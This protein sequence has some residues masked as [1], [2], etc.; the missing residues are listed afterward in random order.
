MSTRRQN[1]STKGLAQD[2][3][4]YDAAVGTSGYNPMSVNGAW[5]RAIPSLQEKFLTDPSTGSSTNLSWSNTAPNFVEFDIKRRSHADYLSGPTW[6]SLRFN[7]TAASTAYGAEYYGVD[8]L[9]AMMIDKVEFIYNTRVL[10]R[11]YGW[12]LPEWYN[13]LPS[14]EATAARVGC[15]GGFSDDPETITARKQYLQQADNYLKIRLFTPWENY[16]QGIWVYALPTA[17]T[18]RVTFLPNSRFIAHTSTTAPTATYVDRMNLYTEGTHYLEAYRQGMYNSLYGAG[19]LSTKI[20]TTDV[21][22]PTALTSSTTTFSSTVAVPLRQLAN[23]CYL[24]RVNAYYLGFQTPQTNSSGANT[25]YEAAPSEYLP[26]ENIKLVD[27][28]L[29]ITD[30]YYYRPKGGLTAKCTQQEQLDWLIDPPRIFPESAVGRKQALI[31]FCHPVLCEA[32]NYDGA[33][34]TIVPRRYT[35][36]EIVIKLPDET[37]TGSARDT[38]VYRYPVGTGA[39]VNVQLRVQAFCHNFMTQKNGDI[40]TLFVQA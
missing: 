39:Q 34:G 11:V 40:K 4:F 37:A 29:Q 30:T 28:A 17:L 33:F 19:A 26:I 38:M 18:V 25:V 9:G 2:Q 16:R 12:E 13:T 3:A 32:S 24:F 22:F 15:G 23:S 1:F 21:E 14:A 8:N 5:T 35:A 36:P 10:T 20:Y 6:L 27:G 7:A 31:P